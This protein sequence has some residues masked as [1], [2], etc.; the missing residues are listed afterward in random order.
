MSYSAVGSKTCSSSSRWQIVVEY[1]PSYLAEAST[2]SRRNSSNRDVDDMNTCLFKADPARAR[3]GD[4]VTP[5][6][7]VRWGRPSYLVS[8]MSDSTVA[9]SVQTSGSVATDHQGDSPSLAPVPA[10]HHFTQHP[11]RSW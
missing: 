3:A 10:R 5:W 4:A 2:K 9:E 1:V 7:I 8:G 11:R 6:G